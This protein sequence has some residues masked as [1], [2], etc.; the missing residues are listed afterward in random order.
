MRG[1][2]LRDWPPKAGAP[3]PLVRVAGG[4][5]AGGPVVAPPRR[6]RADRP[7]RRRGLDLESSGR[8]Q[9]IRSAP[10]SG[11]APGACCRKAGASRASGHRGHSGLAGRATA[12]E[13]S[14]VLAP[15]YRRTLPSLRLAL[16]LSQAL[17]VAVGAGDSFRGRA[18]ATETSQTRTTHSVSTSFGIDPPLS[19]PASGHSA[20]GSNQSALNPGLTMAIGTNSSSRYCTQTIGEISSA[21]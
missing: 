4:G 8:L 9:S 21:A 6:C 17:A 1:R 11:L 7:R 10:V 13:G 16:F 5:P 12:V 19:C 2:G 3:P 15:G 14:A 18:R 20:S